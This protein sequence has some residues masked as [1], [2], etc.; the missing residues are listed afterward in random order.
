MAK[1]IN[2]TEYNKER[3]EY[4]R[5]ESFHIETEDEQLIESDVEKLVRI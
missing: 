3:L 5:A 2:A 1:A 4:Q